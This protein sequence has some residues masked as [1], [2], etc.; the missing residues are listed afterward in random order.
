MGARPCREGYPESLPGRTSSSS[1]PAPKP[2]RPP[3]KPV[4]TVKTGSRSQNCQNCQH[5]QNG[6]A[7]EP[8][9]NLSKLSKLSKLAPG[10]SQNCQ[11]WQ[12]RLFSGLRSPEKR[13]FELFSGFR[14][15]EN[16][17][18]M[19]GP[20]MKRAVFG[21]PRP[22]KQGVQAGFRVSEPGNIG[23]SSGFP[24]FGARKQS[25]LPGF[26]ASEPGNTSQTPGFRAPKP[27]NSSR[28]PGFGLPEKPKTAL[29]HLGF[30][31]S[32]EAQNSARTPG[33]WA[34]REAQKHLSNM[35]FLG[36]SGSPETLLEHAVFRAPKPG[37]QT[38]LWAGFP[39]SEA[40]KTAV[41]G[42][43]ILSGRPARP[44]R[45]GRANLS[46]L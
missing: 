7:S 26:R 43:A 39:G 10:A 29:G 4:K 24:C 35:R 2:A 34:S 41:L 1:G 14:S 20:P 27:G 42:E 36:F 5:G 28:T 31:A 32:R 15:P 9:R 13:G 40:R 25:V 12:N 46:K 44:P 16:P 22:R 38:P 45:P 19:R 23:C 18:F 3:V 37:K 21:V 30:W 33:F 6:P 8:A 11:N 17:D